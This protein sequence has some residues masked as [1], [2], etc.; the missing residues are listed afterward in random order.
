MDAATQARMLEMKWAQHHLYV[1]CLTVA[2]HL[3]M[4]VTDPDYNPMQDSTVL[5]FIRQCVES[6]VQMESQQMQDMLLEQET[7]QH[8]DVHGDDLSDYQAALSQGVPDA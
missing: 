1:T 4:P 3:D 6:R 5:E 2:M 7:I 8:M